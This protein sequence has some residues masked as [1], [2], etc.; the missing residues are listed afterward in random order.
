MSNQAGQ[1][2]GRHWAG[3]SNPEIFDPTQIEMV[4]PKARHL[5]KW[6]QNPDHFEIS[7]QKH[8]QTQNFG[9]ELGFVR[10]GRKSQPNQ[11]FEKKNKLK[12]D[13]LT[14]FDRFVPIPPARQILGEQRNFTQNRGEK[15]R[16]WNITE[17]QFHD[18]EIAHNF[19]SKAET[20]QLSAERAERLKIARIS[21]HL[22]RQNIPLKQFK[23][24]FANFD[25]HSG[26]KWFQ[27]INL[28]QW[29]NKFINNKN[30]SI[31]YINL[32]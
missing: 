13:T 2:R 20:R 18:L 15:Y 27:F 22:S 9:F 6:T 24:I 21:A 7:T 25:Q 19:F 16:S 30:N 29:I 1:V 8:V 11:I 31:N 32:Y 23:I 28:V 14:R 12:I 26:K 4:N 10:L 3:S 5:K 17:I